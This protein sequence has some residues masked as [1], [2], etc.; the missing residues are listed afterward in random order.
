MQ[1]KR[2]P[3]AD[4]RKVFAPCGLIT[5]TARD[6]RKKFT[7]FGQHTIDALILKRDPPCSIA[8]IAIGFE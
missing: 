5:K 7:F 3:V 2:D 8:L 1:Q 6:L 4:R